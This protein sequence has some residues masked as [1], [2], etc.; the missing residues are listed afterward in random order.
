MLQQPIITSAPTPE[1]LIAQQEAMTNKVKRLS[2]MSIDEAVLAAK[3][4][5]FFAIGSTAETVD[6]VTVIKCKSQ[7]EFDFAFCEALAQVNR[8]KVLQKKQLGTSLNS[9]QD[10]Y[11]VASEGGQ[12]M[13][14]KA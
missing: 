10:I 7:R 4:D 3:I 5:R 11:C 1:R 12:L 8:A 14:Q 9:E 6:G 2:K 13:I